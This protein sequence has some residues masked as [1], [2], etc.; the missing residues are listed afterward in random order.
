MKSLY[1][2]QWTKKEIELDS[3]K[4]G[5]NFRFLAKKWYLKLPQSTPN[6]L[7][8]DTFLQRHFSQKI[9]YCNLSYTFTERYCSVFQMELQSNGT[10]GEMWS[11]ADRRL[12]KT[13][14]L[15]GTILS[16]T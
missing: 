14:I 7:K 12:N 16:N 15:H 5:P 10:C 4:K 6:L 9:V 2:L 1:N 13:Y 3:T 11:L 8:R